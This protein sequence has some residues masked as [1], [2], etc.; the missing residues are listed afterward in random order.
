MI[1]RTFFLAACSLIAATASAEIVQTTSSSVGGPGGVYFGTIDQFDGPLWK[2]R[3]DITGGVGAA[4]LG[5]DTPFTGSVGGVFSSPTDGIYVGT[6]L[7]TSSTSCTGSYC[8]YFFGASS[9][10][11]ITGAALALFIG[12]GTLTYSDAS[13]LSISLPQ[14]DYYRGT[15]TAT[16]TYFAGTPEP[17]TWALMVGGFGL[18]G[19]AMRRRR[20]VRV[21]FA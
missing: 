15:T 3:I 6:A 2:V 4:G 17:A 13:G 1:K 7:G 16:V 21:S 18:V 9:S 12:T 11:T 10:Q 20:A 14:Y 8:S 5:A 19:A